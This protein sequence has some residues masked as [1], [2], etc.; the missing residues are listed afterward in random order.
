MPP[1]RTQSSQNLVEQEGRVLLAIQAVKK[2]EITSMGGPS[3]MALSL[4]CLQTHGL[5]HVVEGSEL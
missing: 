1:I 2:Q 3:N 4:R 5:P